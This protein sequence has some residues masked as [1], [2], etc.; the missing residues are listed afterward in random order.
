MNITIEKAIEVL[1]A[2]GYECPEIAEREKQIVM[3][4]RA[5]ESA[6]EALQFSSHGAVKAIES[7]LAATE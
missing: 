2:C 6:K 3:L 4:R 1:A 5:C 7:A